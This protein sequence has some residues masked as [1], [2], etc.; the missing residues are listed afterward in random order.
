MRKK[1]ILI[2]ED[3]FDVLEANR[4]FLESEG[5]EVYTAI[6]LKEARNS[7]W[8]QPPDLILLDVLLP[9]G[10]GYDFCTE[11]RKVTAAP[12]IFLTCMDDTNDIISGFS[13]GAD[14]YITKP[15]NMDILSARIAARLGKSRSAGIISLPPLKIDLHTGKVKM[16]D[17]EIV[18]STK[19]MQLLAFFA[20]NTGQEFLP[21]EIY[22]RVWGETP[23]RTTNNTIRVHISNLRSKLRLD[24]DT[25]F[26]IVLT[27]NKGYMLLRTRAMTS[28]G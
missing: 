27:P 6:N 25:P 10:T 20:E 23:G 1:R 16:K 28:E 4:I 8:E 18:L 12:I 21:D 14:D 7:V 2:V 11:I 22:H 19:E 9:D 3:E 17:E 5:Y 24:E 15:Y 26:E 13:L